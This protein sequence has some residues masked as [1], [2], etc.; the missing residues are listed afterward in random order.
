MYESIKLM[1]FNQFNVFRTFASIFFASL[2]KNAS[3]RAVFDITSF[4]H[5][6]SL[7]R[8]VVAEGQK[9]MLQPLGKPIDRCC[10]VLSVITDAKSFAICPDDLNNFLA[11]EKTVLPFFAPI[12]KY[13]GSIRRHTVLWGIDER[14]KVATGE[15]KNTRFS[16]FG[17]STY[18]HS[19][20][21]YL[22]FCLRQHYLLS[23]NK[24][25]FFHSISEVIFHF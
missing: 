21:I 19:T 13:K 7:I 9:H 3:M 22:I 4:S 2:G 1:S 18:V 12:F 23:N 25:T 14:Q 15:K 6:I 11:D 10:V 17:R 5:L 8:Q 24:H 16:I 20:I